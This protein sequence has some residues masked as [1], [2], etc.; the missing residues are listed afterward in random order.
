MDQIKSQRRDKINSKKDKN[1]K[2]Y[3]TKHLRQIIENL[4]RQKERIKKT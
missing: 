4:E 2:I 3:N 1:D